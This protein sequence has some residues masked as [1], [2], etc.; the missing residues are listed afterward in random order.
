[1]SGLLLEA[2]R[3]LRWQIEQDVYEHLEGKMAPEL[4]RA[5]SSQNGLGLEAPQ[6]L[7]RGGGVG[8]EPHPVGEAVRPA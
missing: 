7:W 5:G 1:M 2:Q 4:W 8:P 6:L 3:L